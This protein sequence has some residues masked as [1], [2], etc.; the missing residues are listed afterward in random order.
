MPDR[1]L[2]IKILTRLEKTVEDISEAL[3]KE[4][5]KNQ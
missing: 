4:I 1:E 5:K 2:N 3:N